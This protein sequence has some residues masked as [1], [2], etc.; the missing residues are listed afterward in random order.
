MNA[1]KAK[2]LRKMLR[3]LGDVQK[4]EG[5]EVAQV[6][7]IENERN[8][9][10]TLV[11]KQTLSSIADPTDS[12][13]VNPEAKEKATER[14]QIAS[15]TVTVAPNTMRGLYKRIKKAVVGKTPRDLH[16]PGTPL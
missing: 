5:K 2:R 7:Y 1:K 6:S 11:P 14:V 3:Q 4:A 12:V 8:R 13:E 10:Y 9:K 16:V 15:G